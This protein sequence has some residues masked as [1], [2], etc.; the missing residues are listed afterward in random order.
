MIASISASHS[1][2]PDRDRF[3]TLGGIIGLRGYPTRFRNGEGRVLFTV[4]QRYY[5]NYYPFQLVRLGAAAFI[6]AGQAWGDNVL[7]ETNNDSL[8]NAGLGIRLVSSRGVARK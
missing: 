1:E 5:R 8:I 6:D 4:E 2:R 3:T 7:G